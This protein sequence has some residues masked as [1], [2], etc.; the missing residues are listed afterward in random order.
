M[1]KKRIPRL[2]PEEEAERDERLRRIR[3]MLTERG[4]RLQADRQA[5]EQARAR[6]RRLFPFFRAGG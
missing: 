5:L 1:A 2:S 6:R 3:E 4:A